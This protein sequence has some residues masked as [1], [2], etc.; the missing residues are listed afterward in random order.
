MADIEKPLFVDPVD[1]GEITVSSAANGNPASNLNRLEAAGLTWKTAVAPSSIWA[2]GR[3]DSA[4]DIDFM[5]I[6]LANAQPGTTF[7]LRLGLS[8]SEVDGATARYDSGALPFISPAITRDDGLYHSF[9]RLDELVN[10][11]WWRIDISGHSG[12]FEAAGIVMG[13]VIE[14]SRFYDKDFERGVDDLG[15]F[16]FNRFGVPDK[17]E[18][19]K[20]RTLLFTLSWLSE[21]EYEDT[22][23]PL[24]EKIGTSELIYCC[25]DPAATTWRQRKTYLG[26]L[27]RAP[28]ARGGVKP[29]YK[30]MELQIRSII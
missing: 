14:P 29:R 25:F 21:A 27:G 6:L 3:M 7:R 20:L 11:T 9:L 10:A 19:V 23:G 28:F 13:E 12:A 17:V 24:S 16:D 8:K 1:L 4:K 2:R 30:S 18:G 5:S 26:V 15:A 22:F